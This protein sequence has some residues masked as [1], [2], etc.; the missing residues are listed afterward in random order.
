MLYNFLCVTTI[1][2]IAMRY[3]SNTEAPKQTKFLIAPE[4]K[5]CRKPYIFID[6]KN[7]TLDVS[8]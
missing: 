2:M 8:E 1:L 7:P 4:E 5:Y 3:K 6:K